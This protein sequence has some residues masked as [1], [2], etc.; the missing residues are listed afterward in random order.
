MAG[1]PK[2]QLTPLGRFPGKRVLTWHGKAL[3]ASHG[4][5]LLRWEPEHSLSAWT[6]V[7][8]FQ[9]S[10][11]RRL[12]AKTRLGYRLHRD[13][14]HALAILL[15][16]TLVAVLP[17]AIAVARPGSPE[18]EVTWHVQRGTRPLALATTPQGNVYWGE[19]FD[20]RERAAVHV[21]GSRDGGHTW[22]VVYTFPADS[23]RHVHS[24]TYDAH[25]DCLWVLTGDLG[26]ECRILRVAPDWSSVDVVLFGNQQTR[27]VTLVPLSDALYF[28][29]DTPLEQNYVYRLRRDGH[30]ERLI[31][32][33][34]SSFW[35]CQVNQAL[36]FSTVVEP[37][38]VNR[39][40]RATLYG[41][42]DGANWATL[43]RWQR[44]AWPSRLFQYANIILPSGD[45]DTDI[46]AATGLAVCGEDQVTHLWRVV[47]D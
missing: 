41:S 26:D 42:A 24:I 36:F 18:F 17:G 40:S 16:D 45:N 37:S 19:Y 4:Y 13:G 44:D 32:L 27:A 25:A 6:P 43:V 31:L 28:A 29:T 12:S 10:L 34:G 21:Y 46:L 39:D 38:P 8:R 7:A 2:L 47:T 33:A 15:D 20:N 3:Y 35:S 9:P 23:I 30:L 22:D 1:Q 11:A 14:F 5:Q